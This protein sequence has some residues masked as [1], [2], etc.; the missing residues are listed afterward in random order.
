M[1]ELHEKY[2]AVTVTTGN[3][4]AIYMSPKSTNR[5]TNQWLKQSINQSI[6]QS[7]KQ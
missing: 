3:L 4:P 1:N 7:S 2:T 6:E 5:P